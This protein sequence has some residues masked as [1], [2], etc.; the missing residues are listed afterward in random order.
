MSRPMRRT[1]L[2]TGLR[3]DINQLFRDGVLQ[4][5]KVTELSDHC[6]IN[7]DGQQIAQA[8]IS[9]NMTIAGTGTM[10]IVARWIDH[11]TLC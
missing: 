6:W 4:P 11:V 5:G 1:V 9:S 7:D 8:R 2:E 3:L 10:H